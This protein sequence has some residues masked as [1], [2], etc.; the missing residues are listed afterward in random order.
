[1]RIAPSHIMRWA[2]G[3]CVIAPKAVPAK[4]RSGF[5]SGTAQIK[6]LEQF[7]DSKKR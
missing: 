2:S 5:A 1:M 3:R 4:V 7:C 6:E